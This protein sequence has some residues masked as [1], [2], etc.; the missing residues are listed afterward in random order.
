MT[1][2]R[3]IAHSF[4]FGHWPLHRARELAAISFDQEMA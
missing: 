2:G 4:I 3:G 1:A